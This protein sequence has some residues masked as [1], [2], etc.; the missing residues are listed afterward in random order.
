M[1]SITSTSHSQI[2]VPMN[3]MVKAGATTAVIAS[4]SNLLILFIAEALFSVTSQFAA[5]NFSA[6]MLS[7]VLAAIGGTIAFTLIVQMF[8]SRPVRIF[9]IVASVVF[10]LSLAAPI[11]AGINGLPGI[12]PASMIV[13]LTMIIMHSVST[14]TIVVSLTTFVEEW[15]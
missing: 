14:G 8:P 10:L 3:C 1:A 13:V 7:S 9:Q 15:D 11:N 5:L 4:I 6:V 12:A 2:S